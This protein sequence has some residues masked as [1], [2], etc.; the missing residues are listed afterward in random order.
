MAQS[1]LLNSLFNKIYDDAHTFV[2][3][4]LP[5]KMNLLEAIYIR[6][7]VDLL[8]GLLITNKDSSAYFLSVQLHFIAQR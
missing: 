1:D 7:C 4:K 3:T 2:Q 6:Q 8:E 5:V